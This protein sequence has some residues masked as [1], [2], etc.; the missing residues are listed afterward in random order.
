[1]AIE[2]RIKILT[3]AEIADLFGP[4]VLNEN[5]QRFFFTLNDH[6]LAI[7]QKI[8]RRDQRC[9]F[10]VLLGYFKV[11]PITLSPGYHQ[12]KH[13]VKYVCS[14]VFPG[15]GLRP[16][17]L[18][19]KSRVRIYQRIYELTNH[20]RWENELHSAALTTDLSEHAQVWA[21]PRSLFDRAIEY[22]SAQ[23]I[24]IPGYS[25][26]QDIISGVVGVSND[27]LIRQLEDLISADLA[28]ML[29]DL[30]EGNDSLTLRRLRL[31]AR[32]FTG[33]EL[34]KELAVHRHIQT[35]M[36]EINRVLSE[37][38]IS[39][40]NQQYFAERVTYYGA[41]LKRQPIGYQRLYL[42][43]YLQ[44]RWQ[45]ALERIADGFVHHIHQRKQKAK[46][47]AREAVYQDWQRAA[48]NVGKAAQV[49]FLFIDDRVDQ[50]QPFG[51]LK[52]QA[53]K[54]IA[55]KDLESVCLFL[56]DQKRSVD[57]ATW[58][59]FDHRVGLREGLLRELF[60][61][62]RFEGSEK[63]RRLAAALYRAQGDFMAHGGISKGATD[64]RLPSK[65]NSYRSC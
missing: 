25:V 52:Q 36:P 41:K 26:L 24:S 40:K 29:S 39:L 14:E 7:S 3:E 9:M 22:L 57:E 59:Y 60:L 32:N 4:P 54:L 27:Q 31:S 2:K 55:A 17:N 61:C 11:K 18:T 35:W 64:S 65:K 53:L 30:V 33:S 15:P 42:L 12:I 10:T 51:Q 50:Q 46:I 48:S 34:Q 13:D 23:Q 20:H 44:S 56:N 21:Q 38:S 16:F 5:D 28:S 1:M 43:C 8:R 19:Q 45:Q 6:E 37:L 58:Q 47:Y 63:T 49:L 62:L